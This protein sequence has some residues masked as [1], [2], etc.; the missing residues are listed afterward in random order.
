MTLGGRVFGVDVNRRYK[1]RK[2]YQVPLFDFNGLARGGGRLT[3]P[4]V[5]LYISS[6]RPDRRQSDRLGERETESL[7]RLIRCSISPITSPLREPLTSVLSPPIPGLH[8]HLKYQSNIAYLPPP[9]PIPTHPHLHPSPHTPQVPDPAA[10]PTRPRHV[11]SA[12]S[13]PVHGAHHQL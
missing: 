11:D 13:H 12:P 5:V 10:P 6:Y 3:S 7:R 8:P 1:Y 4:S 2:R 9:L